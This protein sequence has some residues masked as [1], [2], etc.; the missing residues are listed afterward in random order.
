MK[1]VLALIAI[2]I[3]IT[4]AATF[5]AVPTAA[6]LQAEILTVQAELERVE[7]VLVAPGALVV[8]TVDGIDVV[9]TTTIALEAFRLCTTYGLGASFVN[10]FVECTYDGEVFFHADF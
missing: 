10:Q 6:D 9:E 2:I 3:A 7:N 5:A 1:Q 8:V 4:P